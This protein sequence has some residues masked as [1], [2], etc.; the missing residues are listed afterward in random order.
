[1][2]RLRPVKGGWSAGGHTFDDRMRCTH[3][4]RSWESQQRRPTYCAKVA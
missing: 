4:R 3:C 2:K 1:V